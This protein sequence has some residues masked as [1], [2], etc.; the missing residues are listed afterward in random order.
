M[1]ADFNISFRSAEAGGEPDDTFGGTLAFM[2]PEHLEAFDRFNSATPADVDEQSDIY[3]LGIV[4]YELLAGKFPFKDPKRDVTRT[5]F[6]GV[7]ANWRRAAPAPIQY[8]E[9]TPRKVLEHTLAKSL[10]PDKADRFRTGEEF[11]AALDGCQ[12]LSEVEK[13]APPAISITKAVIRRPLVWAM[14]LIF[15]PQVVGS[16][17]NIAYNRYQIVDLLSEPQQALFTK[18]VTWYNVIVYPA[19]LATL[20]FF[21]RPVFRQWKALQSSERL[22]AEKV[23]AVRRAALRLPIWV[24]IAA[25]VGWLPGGILFPALL[26]PTARNHQHGSL[27]A[28][29]HIVYLLRMD[30]GGVLV[31]WHAVRGDAGA[32]STAVDRCDQL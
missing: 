20:F 31:L 16:V 27:L 11:A 7:L 4:I 19:A 21:F 23:N 32:V 13:V 8:G 25:A 14:L 3:S 15:L 5:K 24:L 26:A 12:R 18:L 2:A 9:P 6:V 28:L 22:D 17:V 29:Y 1:L 30:R 10:S